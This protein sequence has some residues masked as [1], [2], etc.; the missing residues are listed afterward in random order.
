[1]EDNCE[2][3][4][5]FQWLVN[6]KIIKENLFL[7]QHRCLAHGPQHCIMWFLITF[8]NYVYT[9]LITQFRWSGI[10][11]IAMF[12]GVAQKSSTIRVVA[13]CQKRLDSPWYKQHSDRRKLYMKWKD[14]VSTWVEFLRTLQIICLTWDVWPFLMWKKHGCIWS[15]RQHQWNF[16]VHCRLSDKWHLTISWVV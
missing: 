5:F 7:I 2:G 15:L 6:R 16:L 8:V 11:L 13:L 12:T 1:M 14:T 10:P 3:N 9:I 4:R